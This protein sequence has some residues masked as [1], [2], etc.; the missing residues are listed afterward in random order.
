MVFLL[1]VIVSWCNVDQGCIRAFDNADFQVNI[2]I[3][4]APD[5]SGSGAT[6]TS[7]LV[8]STSSSVEG[9]IQYPPQFYNF[10]DAVLG[11][12]L[13][14]GETLEIDADV[15]INLAVQRDYTFLITMTAE[16]TEG[17]ECT[18]VE[19]LN[20]TAG[21]ANIGPEGGGTCA[22]LAG[23]GGGGGGKDKDKDKDKNKDKA[24]DERAISYWNL[25][26]KYGGLVRGRR[27]Y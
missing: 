6:V 9:E 17:L 8:A 21:G 13:V 12:P 18:G 16:T 5:F 10:T 11:V 2:D 15:P 14:A 26:Q 7:L 3:P 22:A 23:G 27:K 20:F 25:Q 4:I 24:R 1:A 19:L